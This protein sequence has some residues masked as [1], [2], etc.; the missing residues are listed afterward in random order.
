[1][2]R[3]QAIL[4][5]GVIAAVAAVAVPSLLA[6]QDKSAIVKQR[7]ETMKELSGHMKAINEFVE[8]GTGSAEDV[9][10]RAASIQQ[11]AAKIP[12]LFPE[13]TSMNDGVGK[14]GAKPAIWFDWPGFEA[15]AHKM[16]EE[17]GKL[18]S[19]GATRDQDAIATQFAALGKSGCGG[20]HTTFRQ[21][22]D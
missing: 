12:S 5:G 20:C 15:A 19:A 11:V 18:A 10:A 2:R 6:A 4:V 14:S 17:A 3:L 7:Q 13:G 1:M 8:S 22:L 21:K 9:A 16:G